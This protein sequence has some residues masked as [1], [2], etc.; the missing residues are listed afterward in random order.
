MNKYSDILNR[1]YLTC[2]H[3]NSRTSPKPLQSLRD[4]I[5]LKEITFNRYLSESPEVSLVSSTPTHLQ[6]P[7]GISKF[8]YEHNQKVSDFPEFTSPVKSSLKLPQISPKHSDFSTILDN[9]EKVLSPKTRLIHH[10]LKEN[11]AQKF[12]QASNEFNY[13]RIMCK[14]KRCPMQFKIKLY[15]G[16]IT[17]YVSF[18]ESQP[19]QS[20]HDRNFNYTYFEI[21]EKNYNFKNEF[22]FV[23]VKTFNYSVYKV[24]VSFGRVVNLADI[25]K[26][27]QSTMRDEPDYE[28]NFDEKAKGMDY[29]KK[30]IESLTSPS[31]K[32]LERG[33]ENWQEKKNQVKKRKKDIFKQKREKAIEK[34][35][36]KERRQEEYLRMMQANER[37]SFRKKAKVFWMSFFILHKTSN[38][39][40]MK[41]RKTRESRLHTIKLINK[42]RL[43]QRFFRSKVKFPENSFKFLLMNHSLLTYRK[44]VLPVQIRQINKSLMSAILFAAHRNELA[45]TFQVYYKK[46]ITI[47]RHTREFLDLKSKRIFSLIQGWNRVIEKNLFTKRSKAS[48]RKTSL[49]FMTIPQSR[50]NSILQEYYKSKWN[51]FHLVVRNLLNLAKPYRVVKR[52]LA[53]RIDPITF[54]FL[55]D[56]LKMIELIQISMKE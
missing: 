35:T 53:G 42:V 18:T 56:D 44:I 13:F 45:H 51:D 40:L 12:T 39:L 37:E 27:K 24:K 46:I 22:V 16:K 31:I 17:S 2:Q 7:L 49:K 47:Q 50:R 54:N 10:Y 15:E 23:A 26:V 8:S 3:S 43:I 9:I 28:K 34:L 33:S 1:S 55:P 29:I 36:R 5:S 20:V 30:N 25:K 48:R 19:N 52:F 11:E 6:S 38:Y 32:V 41:V 21:S 4:S 14:G